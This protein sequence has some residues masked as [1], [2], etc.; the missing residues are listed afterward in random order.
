MSGSS[1]LSW[2]HLAAA[3]VDV[4]LHSGQKIWDYAAGALVLEE[5]G[6]A[7]S[8]MEADDFWSGPAWRR[9]A[10]AARSPSLL[11]EWRA[12]IRG[13]LAAAA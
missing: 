13:H 5:A 8:A 7:L 1:A 10:I 4:M 2:C 9:S 11:E 6:G 3:R 12:W